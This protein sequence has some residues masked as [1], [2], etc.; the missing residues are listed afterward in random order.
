VWRD[1]R[2]VIA[3]SK[4]PARHESSGTGPPGGRSTLETPAR[5]LDGGTLDGGTLDD[6]TLD[7]GTLD[8]GTLDGG[9][10]DDVP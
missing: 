3:H 9:T 1:P 8:G 4:R 2:R 5:R 6:G 10:L 7:D